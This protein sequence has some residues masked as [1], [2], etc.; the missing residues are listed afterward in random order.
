M[1]G[2]RVAADKALER[3]LISYRQMHG[4]YKSGGDEIRFWQGGFLVSA[5]ASPLIFGAYYLLGDVTLDDIPWVL[6]N[7]FWFPLARFVWLLHTRRK[8]R[9][10]LQ[11]LKV[12]LDAIGFH[13][14]CDATRPYE[15]KLVLQADT[16]AQGK[17]LTFERGRPLDFPLY[18][19]AFRI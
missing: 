7:A 15:R 1:T 3:L 18:D 16:P 5:I 14:A 4:A 2:S 13:V 12:E 19:R 9:R 11:R 10:E 6:A 8:V 17:Y